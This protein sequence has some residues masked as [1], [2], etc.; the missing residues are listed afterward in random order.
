M[1]LINTSS[2]LMNIILMFYVTLNKHYQNKHDYSYQR[3]PLN[4]QHVYTGIYCKSLKL[5]F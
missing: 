3:E 4:D 2:Y 1:S 5:A